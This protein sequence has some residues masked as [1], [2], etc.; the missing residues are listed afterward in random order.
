MG[1]SP[2]VTTLKWT[3]VNLLKWL[4]LSSARS[5]V[6]G[7]LKDTE[8]TCDLDHG[9]RDRDSEDPYTQICKRRLYGRARDY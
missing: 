7:T 5:L 4:T 2:Y 9:K 3:G 6:W 1:S 8:C